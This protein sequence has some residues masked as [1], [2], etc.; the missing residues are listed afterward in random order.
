M[1]CA[2]T[3][4]RSEGCFDNIGGIKNVYLS[5]YNQL[6]NPLFYKYEIQGGSFSESITNDENGVSYNQ[7]LNFTLIK[8]DL[9]TRLELDRAVNI[10]LRYLVEFN[11]GS[12]RWGG[13]VNG[14]SITSYSIESGGDKGDFVGYNITIEGNEE[15]SAPF[16]DILDTENK[17]LLLE[18]GFNYL[19]EDNGKVILQ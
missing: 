17:Y 3:K 5:K 13:F 18:D 15:A 12:V 9:S 4:G 2:L 1:S 8:P 6:S 7:S 16:T 10:D 14:A 19:Y 11:D